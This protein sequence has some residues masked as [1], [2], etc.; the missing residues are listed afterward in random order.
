VASWGGVALDAILLRFGGLGFDDIRA[1]ADLELTASVNV[2][3]GARGGL[4]AAASA[5][6]LFEIATLGAD[7]E[8]AIHAE[9]P[10]RFGGPVGLYY[11]KGRL[12]FKFDQSLEAQ[13]N[14]IFTLVAGIHAS[15]LGFSWSKH[16][17]L[18][19]KSLGYKWQVGTPLRVRYNNSPDVDMP[20][21][22]ED[23]KGALPDWFKGIMSA[24][25][26]SNEPLV[27]L[28]QTGPP[29]GTGGG[30]QQPG[31]AS[32]PSRRTPADPINM[33]WYKSPGLYPTWI[34]LGP[35]QYYFT[36]PDYVQVPD[37]RGLADVR[38]QADSSGRIKIGVNPGSKF[39]PKPGNVWPRTHAG[40]V[41]SGT[42]Q[43]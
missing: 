16:W 35:N 22:E 29:T 28:T 25:T 34:G 18:M 15:L 4:K 2:G 7:L 20:L 24:A 33:Y 12:E 11:S 41:R 42:I 39:Y 30:S 36:E 6:G 14:L 1:L 19:E 40:V 13:L 37:V 27:P 21:T 8:T 38:R 5:L 26:S 32:A 43:A 3:M 9:F 23:K 10:L 17:K 31:T